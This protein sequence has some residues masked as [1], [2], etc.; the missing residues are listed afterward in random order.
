MVNDSQLR[1]I[2]N[3]SF[4]LNTTARTGFQGKLNFENK[5][6][7]ANT[8]FLLENQEQNKFSTLTNSFK[9]IYKINKTIEANTLLNFI[10]P[11]LSMSNHYWFLDSEL[12]F[13][14]KNKKIDYSIIGKNLTNNKTFKTI[15]I[16][17]YSKT[18]SSHNLIDRFIMASI[19][20]NF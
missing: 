7:Y 19:R 12:R 15:S 16:T 17:D 20:F 5:I 18:V 1:N 2:E 14:S 6:V 9:T 11:D 13:T 4:L 8:I 10:S 3:R